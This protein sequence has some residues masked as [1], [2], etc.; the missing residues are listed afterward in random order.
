MG[1]AEAG[2]A[3]EG[4]VG[5]LRQAE[6]FRQIVDI[7]LGI[8]VGLLA[9]AVVIALVGVTNTLSLSVIERTRESAMLRAIGPGVSRVCEIGMMP[10]PG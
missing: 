7:I 4:E 9:V 10:R 5:E 2:G 8:M 1:R 6:Q 3:V